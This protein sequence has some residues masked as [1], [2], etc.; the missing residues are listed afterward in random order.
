MRAAHHHRVVIGLGNRERGDDAAGRRVVE[1]LTERDL[2]DVELCALD[3]ESSVLLRRLERADAAWIVDACRTGA[4]AGT[5]YRFDVCA[6]ALPRARFGLST[7]DLGLAEAIELARTLGTL[8]KLCIVYALVGGRF[9]IGV[10]LSPPVAQVLPVVAARI[11][12][13]LLESPDPARAAPPH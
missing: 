3:G 5:V 11:I 10:G 2:G 7:H 6:E 9:D 4:P 12:A 1:L 8:P 13:E